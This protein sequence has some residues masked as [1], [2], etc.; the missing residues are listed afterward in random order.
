MS[1]LQL[2]LM[3]ALAALVVVV[4]G[5]TGVLAEQGLRAREMAALEASLL[6]HARLVDALVGDTAFDPSELARLDALADRAGDAADA[7]VT[8][9]ARDGAVVGDSQVPLSALG[10]LDDHSTRPEVIRALRDQVGT[11]T[12][13]SDTLV[14]ELLYVAIPSGGGGVVRLAVDL[15]GVDAAVAELRGELLAAGALGLAGALLLSFLISWLTL[16]Q[17]EEVRDVVGAIADGKLE[18]RLGWHARDELGQ[19][20]ASINRMAEQLRTR[21]DEAT[22]E[23]EQLEAVLASMVDGVLVLDRD[24][25]IQLANPRFREITATWDEVEGRAPIEV[26][27]HPEIDAA[28]REAMDSDD[29]I[30]RELELGDVEERRILL[31]AVAFP[32]AENRAGIVGVF[33]DVTELQRLEQVRT[34]FI[35]NASHELRTPLTSIRGFADTLLAGH[36][37][38]E[39]QRSY[40][41]VIQRNAERL[42]NL[43]DDLLELSRAE[44]RKAPLHPAEV[45][46]ARVAKVLVADLEPRARDSG[47]SIEIEGLA[48]APAWADRRAVE[49]VLTNLLDNAVKYSN[50]EGRIRLVLE[51]EGDTLRI[52]VQDDGIGI[53]AEDQA[54]IFERFYRVDKA[55]SRALGGTGLGLSIV[56]HLVQAM[57]GDIWLESSPGKG[58]RFTFTLPRSRD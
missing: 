33:H 54:R 56:K 52:S 39:E 44:S 45:D 28:L 25:R 50:P 7:R 8:L 30:V 29:P 36:S 41:E 21:L 18:R 19:I 20:A 38:E 49:Q 1:R 11:S 51:Y 35:A 32:S 48:H 37:S 3:G 47:R 34:D 42:T 26:V 17:V 58:S 6:E 13:H 53:P 55:R 10:T 9:I 12:R 43:M 22:A 31:H 5:V 40:V 23:K 15:D 16:R 2:K 27:R 4:V 57:G 24:G 46:V 14:R